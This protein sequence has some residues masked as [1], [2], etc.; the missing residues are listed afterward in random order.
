MGHTKTLRTELV[1]LRF[2]V[3]RDK[4]A[5]AQRAMAP[6]AAMQ[7]DEERIPWKEVFPEFG[8]GDV[9]AGLRSREGITQQDS[10]NA[11]ASRAAIFPPWNT[12]SG[13]SARKWPNGWLLRWVPIT[14]SFCSGGRW[15]TVFRSHVFRRAGVRDG[16][17]IFKSASHNEKS[18]YRINR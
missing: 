11:S 13:P 14:G 16:S 3:R 2:L 7:E 1:E 12:A 15:R 9:L 6:Y 18:G 4:V 5:A 10:P 8:P 17:R